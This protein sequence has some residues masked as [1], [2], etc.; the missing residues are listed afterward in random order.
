[1][2]RESRLE[3]KLRSFRRSALDD[4]LAPTEAIRY[5]PS[6]RDLAQGETRHGTL[7]YL[8]CDDIHKTIHELK[9]LGIKTTEPTREG[10]SPW[11]ADFED[12]VGNR[13][14]IEEI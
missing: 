6:A 2:L 5:R 1:M 14:G 12:C 13:W 10:E 4:R 3:F 7:P 8:L 9:S 11:F